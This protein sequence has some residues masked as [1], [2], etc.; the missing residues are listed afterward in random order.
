MRGRSAEAR[1]AGTWARWWRSRRDRTGDFA[2]HL[3]ATYRGAVPLHFAGDDT[4]RGRIVL[5]FTQTVPVALS[6]YVVT[7]RR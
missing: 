7:R 6:N 2:L 5:K 1:G 3:M 4:L